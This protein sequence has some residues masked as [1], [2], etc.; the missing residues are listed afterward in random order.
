MSDFINNTLKI[1]CNNVHLLQAVKHVMFK[2]VDPNTNRQCP[3]TV[4]KY[5]EDQKKHH[6]YFP[7]KKYEDVPEFIK[8]YQYRNLEFDMDLLLPYPKHIDDHDSVN[9]NGTNLIGYDSYS[10]H[11]A[12]WG[13]KW[14]VADCDI[15]K[16]TDNDIQLSYRTA[17][18][19]NEY[20]IMALI[21][22]A[23]NIDVMDESDFS[24]EHLYSFYFWDLGGK[25]I[26][27]VNEKT[28]KRGY[29][30]VQYDDYLEFLQDNFPDAYQRELKEREKYKM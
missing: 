26:T 30:H 7:D 12:V 21:R 15:M 29:N 17:N 23:W 19:A 9:L 8:N 3:P 1:H 28:K 4:E 14:N 27:T 20:W 11:V 18:G 13:T 25:I 6:E 2:T 24:L 5:L 22:Y 16:Y 10:W